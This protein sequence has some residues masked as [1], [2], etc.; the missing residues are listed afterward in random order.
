MLDKYDKSKKPKNFITK[1]MFI[2]YLSADSL[3]DIVVFIRL[4]ISN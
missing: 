2:L 4:T 3:E 1:H